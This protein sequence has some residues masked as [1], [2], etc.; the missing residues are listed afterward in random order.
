ME[1]ILNQKHAKETIYYAVSRIL[2]R[3]SFNGFRT[4][5]IFYMLGETLKMD[6][7]EAA[8]IFGAF[9]GSLFI[10]Q[11]IGALFGD[12]LIGNRKSIII[13]GIIQAIGVFSLCITSMSGL[14][15]GLVL[16]TIGNGLYTPNFLS[17]FGKS[18]LTKT[19][20]LDSAF[21]ILFLAVNIGSFL[22]P[23]YIGYAMDLYG[24]KIGFLI[25]G[26]LMLLSII[27]IILL[28]KQPIIEIEIKKYSVK[29]I[30][31][32]T[33]LITIV[34]VGLFWIVYDIA[35]IRIL[36]LQ[37]QFIESSFFEIPKY[38]WKSMNLWFVVPISIIAMIVWSYFY[39]SQIAKLI[40]GFIFGI[41][42]FGML[43]F[44]PEIPSDNHVLIYLISLLFLGI[45]EVHISPLIY[46]ILTKYSN[47]KYLTILLSIS[48]IPL[49][50]F[51]L[52]FGLFGNIIFDNPAFALKIGLVLMM[53]I[54]IGLILYVR[55]IKNCNNNKEITI[56]KI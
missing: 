34:V 16:I 40:V 30:N 42:S 29:K 48:F 51:S 49:K 25:A 1:K 15:V 44:I 24:E 12:L 33:I 8:Y 46:S 39:N 13:G 55:I 7:E 54:A 18:Y 14:Y 5:F 23:F 27:P 38:Y 28:K 3:T 43:L 22:G 37:S 36:D 21:T 41:I 20:L 2:E 19:K 47:P 32:A 52:V 17:S 9:M 35:N 11:I 31:I 50:L 56:D 6:K 26:I 53:I 4:I 45:A 10:T